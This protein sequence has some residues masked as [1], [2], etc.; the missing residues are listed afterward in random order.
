MTAPNAGIT[1]P[2]VAPFPWWASGISARSRGAAAGRL[3]SFEL[4]VIPGLLQTE[5]YA[6]AVLSTQIGASEEEISDAVAGRI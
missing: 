3:R 1:D 5:E 4:V 2:T 6:C